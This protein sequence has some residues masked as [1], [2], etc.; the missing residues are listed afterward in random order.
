MTNREVG[1]GSKSNKTKQKQSKNKV[2]TKMV[3][4]EIHHS[5]VI[6]TPTIQYKYSEEAR[7]ER[8]S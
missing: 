2:K 5:E 1:F 8:N 3:I 4:K 6:K 7:K